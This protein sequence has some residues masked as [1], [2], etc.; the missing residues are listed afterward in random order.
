MG[1]IVGLVISVLVI[2][3]LV[4]KI[5][6]WSR[7]SKELKEKTDFALSGDSMMKIVYES[8][9]VLGVLAANFNTL[10]GRYQSLRK[11]SDVLKVET[12]EKGIL[13][14]KVK[15]YESSFSKMNLLTDI[16]RKITASLNV[17]EI[18]KTVHHFIRSSMDVEELELLYYSNNRPIYIGIDKANELSTYTQ[19]DLV[20]GSMVMTW[21]IENKKEVFLNDAPEDY[22][23]YVFEPIVSFKGTK[24]N[25][26]ICIP[27]FLHG[28]PV[29]AIGVTSKNKGAFNEYHLEF[30]R[31]LASYLAVA[32]DNSNV[33][34]L[35]ELGKKVIEEEKEKSDKLLLNILPAEIAEE[36]KEK[37]SAEARDF[38]DV[39]ILFT[40]FKAF[41]EISEKMSAVELVREINFC[42][43]QFDLICEKHGV[44]KIKTIG[45]SYM[46]AGGIPVH[47]EDSVKNT[48]LAGIDMCQFIVDQ[49]KKYDAS[50]KMFFEMRTGIHTGSVVAGIVGVKKFQY[51]V[52][53]D[54][55][56]TASRIESTGEVGQVNISH[57][58]YLR[59][60]NEPE[61]SFEHRGKLNA[62][63]K[64]EI[65][66]YFARRK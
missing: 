29:G 15:S 41:T 28:N 52:W 46:A 47:F 16:G 62:K 30:L 24:P 27:L 50:G 66:M 26:L 33:Y 60:Q 54:T 12:K 4:F 19:L 57:T 39:S 35:L 9:G 49:K 14:E 64:G 37:G 20:S 61:F 7:K 38:E 63:G 8:S 23:Q 18:C 40:D 51:D 2:L 6:N 58:T 65:D 21:A 5:V 48:V 22:S 56:N 25:A 43:E 31:T 1:L 53:G 55:V 45:D 17:D 34:G 42:F 13:D 3:L 44:E 32:L 11:D 59:I 36:L 10:I